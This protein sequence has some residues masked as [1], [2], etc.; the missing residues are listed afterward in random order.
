MITT[1]AKNA[2]PEDDIKLIMARF[3]KTDATNEKIRY[4]DLLGRDTWDFY[5]EDQEKDRDFIIS[6]VNPF[7][8]KEPEFSFIVTGQIFR[9]FSGA[10]LP[11]N[12]DLTDDITGV[13]IVS[14]SNNVSGGRIIVNDT[15]VSPTLGTIVS[16][17]EPLNQQYQIETVYDNTS[18]P[19]IYLMLMFSDHV[20]EKE[21]E[22]KQEELAGENFETVKINV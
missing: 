5:T 12:V 18:A 3:D 16:I 2:L 17:T 4:M 6:K 9:A 15:I 14:F 1:I 13:A 10:F 22:P 11:Y 21:K 8:V 19:F 7:L 20:I